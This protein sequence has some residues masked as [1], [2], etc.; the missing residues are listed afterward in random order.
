MIGN[1]VYTGQINSLI[2]TNGQIAYNTGAIDQLQGTLEN[3]H[4]FWH[5]S[6]IILTLQVVKYRSF[7]RESCQLKLM[8]W[9]EFWQAN[10]TPSEFRG[11]TWESCRILFDRWIISMISSYVIWQWC[12]CVF[13]GCNLTMTCVSQDAIWQWHV[14]LRRSNIPILIA[15]HILKISN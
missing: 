3:S 10:V 8:P 7:G 9:W 4:S 13:P 6:C 15:Y 11:S 5:H 12:V 14:F 2:N 1:R